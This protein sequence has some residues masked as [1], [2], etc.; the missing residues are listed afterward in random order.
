[1]KYKIIF[2]GLLAMIIILDSCETKQQIPT[3]EQITEI[4]IETIKQDSLD[5]NLPICLNL[6]NRYNYQLEYDKELGF[7]P[8]PPRNEKGVPFAFKLYNSTNDNFQGFNQKD[9]LFIVKQ[10][11]V[12][13]DLTLDLKLIPNDF[14]I[15]NVSVVK[16]NELRLYKFL[17]PLFNRNNDFATV[18]YDYQCADCGFGKIVFFRKIGGKWTKI[19][20]FGTWIR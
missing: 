17:I 14:K 13:K 5:I 7:L 20:S 3:R 4:I 9:S 10:V 11:D 8:P 15:K 12:N 16:N 19:K 2:I 6:V 1:M 18:E